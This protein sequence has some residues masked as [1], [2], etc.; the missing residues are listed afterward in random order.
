MRVFT[1]QSASRV[2]TFVTKP[3]LALISVAKYIKYITVNTVTMLSLPFLF[4]KHITIYPIY[5]DR[6]RV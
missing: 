1:L 5:R 2:Y 6:L 4:I 3:L